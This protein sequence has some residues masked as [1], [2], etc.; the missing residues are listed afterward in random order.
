MGEEFSAQEG[1]KYV[2]VIIA[3]GAIIAIASLMVSSGRLGLWAGA[4][5]ILACYAAVYA[6]VRSF[7]MRFLS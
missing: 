6:V 7:R 2:L 5:V 1:V 3:L 4:G